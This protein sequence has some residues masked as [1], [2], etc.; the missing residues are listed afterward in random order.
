L[1]DEIYIDKQKRVCWM[2]YTIFALP[3]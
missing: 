3:I 1:T 2:T